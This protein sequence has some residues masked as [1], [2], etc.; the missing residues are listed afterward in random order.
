M[1]NVLTVAGSSEQKG[2][3]QI[4]HESSYVSSG[5]AGEDDDGVQMGIGL[6]E[7]EGAKEAILRD[8][9]VRQC[10]LKDAEKGKGSDFMEENGEINKKKG[11]LEK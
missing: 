8:G 6:S 3:R 9:G 11:T 1:C 7:E 10:G 5:K 2:S 4:L